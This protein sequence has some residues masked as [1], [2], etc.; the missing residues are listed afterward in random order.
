MDTSIKIGNI[1]LK[2]PVTVASGT[3]GY[4]EELSRFIDLSGIGAIFTK[5]LS[6]KPRQGNRGPRIIETSS[7]MMNSIG[8]ENVGLD[9]FLNE[10][11]PFLIDHGAFVIP[12]IAGY[13]IDENVELCRILSNT[14][15]IHA[16]EL[17]VSCPNTDEGGHSF[18]SD[19]GIFTDLIKKAREVTK[20]ILIVKLSPNVPDPVE[21]AR[22]AKESG[23]D[24]ISAI[25]TLIGMKIDLN[26]RK[27]YFDRKVAGLSGPAIK[28]VAVRMIYEIFE[29]VDLPIIGLGGISCTE[30]ILEF[31]MAGASAISIGTMN[32]V[33][34]GIAQ[35]CVGGLARYM[36]ENKIEDL[37]ELIGLAHK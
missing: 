3:A 4:G 30:D 19:I 13:T 2:N 22:K 23:A 18:S 32:L 33:N 26:T 7:G 34:P 9:V 14:G 1:T 15:H 8:L 12:N 35:E 5:G 31:L 20:G 11:L 6:M 21:Y 37:H 28:P 27:P 16:V 24:A 17:N 10:K 36:A 29:K 25:N